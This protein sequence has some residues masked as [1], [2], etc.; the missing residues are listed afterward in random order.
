LEEVVSKL[1]LAMSPCYTMPLN[2]RNEGT[3]V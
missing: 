3:C 1:M 2:S